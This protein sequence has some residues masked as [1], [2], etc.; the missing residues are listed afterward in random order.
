MQVVAEAKQLLQCEKLNT[1][2]IS[3]KGTHNLNPHLKSC[4]WWAS[5][6]I[7]SLLLIEPAQDTQTIGNSKGCRMGIC[8][9]I[10]AC[11]FLLILLSPLPCLHISHQC[12]PSLVL[13][14]FL[15]CQKKVTQAM[16]NCLLIFLGIHPLSPHLYCSSSPSSPLKFSQLPVDSR[17]R[18]VCDMHKNC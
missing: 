3:E 10:N 4:S 17:N 12:E 2:G 16:E 11:R 14:D 1:E 18:E 6:S 13:L 5:H 8:S 9:Q 15:M 7:Q